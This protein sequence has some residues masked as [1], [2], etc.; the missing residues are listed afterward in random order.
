MKTEDFKVGGL[1]T[2]KAETV[3]LQPKISSKPVLDEDEVAKRKA[4]LLAQ[5]EAMLAKKK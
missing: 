4:K 3:E 1:F 2:S 5:R